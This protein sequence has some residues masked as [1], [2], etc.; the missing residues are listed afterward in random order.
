MIVDAAR[1]TL[2][3]LYLSIAPLLVRSALPENSSSVDPFPAYLV[4]RRQ[5]SRHKEALQACMIRPALFTAS[6]SNADHLGMSGD[7]FVCLSMILVLLPASWFWSLILERV[8]R[9]FGSYLNER[10]QK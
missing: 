4:D 7:A 6:T 10:R 3:P 2:E 8:Q 1:K 5:D 9:K